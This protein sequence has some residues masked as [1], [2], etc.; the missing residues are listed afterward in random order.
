MDGE[1]NLPVTKKPENSDRTLSLALYMAFGLFVVGSGFLYRDSLIRALYSMESTVTE[2]DYWGPILMTLIAAVWAILCL[3]GPVVLGFVGTVYSHNPGMGLLIAVVA[4]SIAEVVGFLVA[5]H[6][7]REPM[8]NWL[9]KKPW[10]Q[11]LEEQAH[12]RGAYG[13]FVIRMM[14]FF[15]NS[16]ANY[17]FGLSA[18]RF[19]PYL[20]ASVLG[21]IPNL[22][23]YILGTAGAIHILRTGLDERTLYF[24]G[25]VICV[26]SLVLVILQGILRRHGRLAEWLPDN[27]ND[28]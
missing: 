11:W 28:D 9:G 26:T 10:Y 22:A 5:R 2:L 18:L 24:A 1:S 12:I 23:V 15:P 20:I 25:I 13:V 21:S 7:G 16:L 3:P 6:I 17:A 4:D 19:W 8:A 14:P 27:V